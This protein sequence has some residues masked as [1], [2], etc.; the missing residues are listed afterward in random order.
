MTTRKMHAD[1]LATDADLVP[2][3]I[4]A[5]FSQWASFAIEAIESGGTSNAITR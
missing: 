5:Q 3:L 1:Q 4:Q 2:R